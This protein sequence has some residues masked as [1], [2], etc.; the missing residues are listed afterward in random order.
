MFTP[1]SLRNRADLHIRA[2]ADSNRP[3]DQGLRIGRARGGK[4][5]HP[6][7]Q[8]HFR[9]G[10]QVCLVGGQGWRDIR[11]TDIDVA[12]LGNRPAIP[13]FDREWIACVVDQPDAI[14]ERGSP[15]SGEK[16]GLGG[17]SP[18]FGVTDTPPLPK[19]WQVLRGVG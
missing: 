10:I 3:A 17:G 2:M 16:P 11:Q 5:D 9:I 15:T 18:R 1:G 12:V 4:I 7:E 19:R 14:V 13:D 8:S 6:L